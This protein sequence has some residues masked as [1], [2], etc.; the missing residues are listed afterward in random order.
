[1]DYCAVGTIADASS[2]G[3]SHNNRV[4]VQRGL[5]LMN[6]RS[7]P[8][9]NALRRILGKEGPWTSADISFQV[10][11]RINARGRLGDAMLSVEFLR[12][13]DE[14]VAYEMALE[15]DANNS[16]RRTVERAS[17]A[18]AVERARHAVANGRFGLC[19]WLGEDGHAGVHGISANRIVEMFG[20][21]TICLSPVAGCGDLATG[22]IRST[23]KVH[24]RNTILEIQRR[25]PGLILGGGGHAGAG[26]IRVRKTDIANLEEAWDECVRESYGHVCP[27]P[28]MLVDGDL[29][30]PT[31]SHTAELAALE[32]F[33]RG[34]EQPVF[35]GEWTIDQVRT[36]GDGTHLKF[37]LRRGGE[38]YDAVWFGAKAADAAVPVQP[39]HSIRLAFVLDAQVFRGRTRLQ[40]IVRGAELPSA[41]ARGFEPRGFS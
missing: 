38:T 12:A 16:E 22:S 6:S 35:F 19:L 36:I 18:L 14:D 7:R 5:H 26:G 30:V 27:E 32:P 25:R 20:K 41:V 15:L 37:A 24:V 13:Q 4:I 10:A 33:G 1:L 3:T 17:T 34:F 31:L 9:W 28:E 2:L 23:P 40:F 39:G 21:P 8:C 29:E 11:T